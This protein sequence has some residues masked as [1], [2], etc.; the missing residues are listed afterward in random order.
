[1][2]IIVQKF[3]GSSMATIEKIKKVA[4]KIVDT[5]KKGHD[6]V[7]VVSAMGKTTDNLINMAREITTNPDH[8]E[9]DML[10]SIGERQSIALL[11]MAIRD[12][13]FPAISL[14]GSQSGIITNTAHN[15]AKILEIR[16]YRIEDA[17]AEGKIVIVAG[18]QG[19]SYL[20]EITTLG[21]G[22]SDTTALALTAALNA[23]Y[24][25]IYSDVDGVYSGDPKVVHLPEKLDSVSY[26]EMLEMAESGAKV[27]AADAILF[28]KYYK[29]KLFSKHSFEAGEGTFVTDEN[30]IKDV[31][32]T[33]SEKDI[34]IVSIDNSQIESFLIYIVEHNILYKEVIYQEKVL[35]IFDI[36]NIHKKEDFLNYL[37]QK[38]ILFTEKYGRVSLIGNQLYKNPNIL[39]NSLN[40]LKNNKINYTNYQLT[41]IK[42]NFIIPV[43]QIDKTTQILHENF[44]IDN[45]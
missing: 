35:F 13:G 17:I 18:F 34:L 25:E 14:T 4:Q 31:V 37:N 39:I 21:R 40:L 9:M 36:K 43:E 22:G 45:K 29:I 1:M 27:L 41:H 32:S 16:P 30:I 6:V 8:R 15:Q 20:K 38:N 23:I 24:C 44:I 42:L 33:S 19:V 26:E 2:A 7:V 3:G 28:A 5:K 10:L 11:S 12:F